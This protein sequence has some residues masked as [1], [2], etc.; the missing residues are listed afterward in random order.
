MLPIYP[1]GS[2]VTSY[3]RKRHEP[4]N[5]YDSRART[6]RH[7]CS[8]LYRSSDL[9]RRAELSSG[10]AWI[11]V[12]I[13]PGDDLTVKQVEGRYHLMMREVANVKHPH[14]M[15]GANLAHLLLEL[16]SHYIRATRKDK[17]RFAQVVPAQG[18]KIHA[19]AVALAKIGE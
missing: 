12:G 2:R 3:R 6:R 18:M 16:P 7:R 5:T 1:F 9:T 11:V 19:F 13:Q 10:L 4:R 14:K 15:F 8:Y 17:A